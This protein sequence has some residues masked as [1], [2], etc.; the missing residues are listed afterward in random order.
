MAGSGDGVEQ[1]VVPVGFEHVIVDA[2]APG[3]YLGSSVRL[4]E[5]TVA[6]PGR[7]ACPTTSTPTRKKSSKPSPSAEGQDSSARPY[8]SWGEVTPGRV[9]K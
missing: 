1:V 6:S 4:L 3:G 8:Q 9:K 5:E 7:S 2:R